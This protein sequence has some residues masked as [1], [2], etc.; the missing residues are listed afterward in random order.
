[1]REGWNGGSNAAA[2]ESGSRGTLEYRGHHAHLPG[3]CPTVGVKHPK[4]GCFGGGS[5]G[6]SE[7]LEMKALS[8][9]GETW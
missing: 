8:S 1:M 3:K 7:Y 4:K 2:V 9:G 5:T 6:F